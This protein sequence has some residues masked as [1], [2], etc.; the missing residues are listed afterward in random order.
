MIF[1][2]QIL[3]IFL[4]I[5]V[6]PI[7]FLFPS[8]RLFFRKRSTDKKKIISKP[9]D[10]SGKYTVWLHA[11]SVGELDQCKALALEFRKNDPSAFLIQSVFSDSVRDSQLEAFPADET[12]HLPIDLP[13]NYDWIFPVFILKF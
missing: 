7:S 11:A 13:F 3:T 1:L 10:L 9:L 6:V 5:F 8:A 2:Y 4:L 12:F